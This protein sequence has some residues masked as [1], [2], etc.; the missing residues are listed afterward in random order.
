MSELEPHA[1]NDY[2]EKAGSRA[3]EGPNRVGAG[4]SSAGETAAP[5]PGIL[6]RLTDEM[7]EKLPDELV[8]EGHGPSVLAR[9]LGISRQAL[10][11]ISTK[12]PVAVGRSRPP[13]CEVE[14]AIVEVAGQNPTDGYRIVSAWVQC[15]LG[16]VINRKRVLRV[17]RERKLIQRRRHEPRRR[18]LGCFQVE[19]PGRTSTA[20]STR[21]RS[22]TAARGRS[23]AG[24]CR[25]AAGPS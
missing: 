19:R 13:A 4:G 21:T 6:E 2:T 11:R 17:M 5:P 23:S 1:F 14:A 3:S 25:C 24:S 8:A 18:R 10:Y 7:R 22:S 9:V 16:R 20:G 15:K 12:P